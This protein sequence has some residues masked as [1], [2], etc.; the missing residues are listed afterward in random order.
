MDRARASARARALAS[1]P[2]NAACAV[3]K[4]RRYTIKYCRHVRKHTAPN[5]HARCR[6]RKRECV[7]VTLPPLCSSGGAATASSKAWEPTKAANAS[8]LGD[9]AAARVQVR[10]LMARLG[11]KR[12]QVA[13]GEAAAAAAAAMTDEPWRWLWPSQQRIRL[14]QANPKVRGT[15]GA[16]PQQDPFKPHSPTAGPFDHRLSWNEWYCLR[17]LTGRNPRTP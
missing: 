15:S 13:K 12:K 14:L 8:G 16:T 10:A 9:K 6:K 7:S 1:T 3:C 17:L 11:A 2:L 4:R 5:W